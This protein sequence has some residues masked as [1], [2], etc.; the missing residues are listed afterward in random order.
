MAPKWYDTGAG[1]SK[2]RK[3]SASTK[4]LEKRKKEKAVIT[5]DPEDET[6]GANIPQKR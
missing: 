3:G 2:K 4:E 1:Q 6:L 5:I